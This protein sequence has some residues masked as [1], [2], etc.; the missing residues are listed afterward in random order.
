MFAMNAEPLALMT[1]MID[2]GINSTVNVQCRF[3][4]AQLKRDISAV[5]YI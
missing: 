4:L 2:Q 1:Q 5:L 3:G